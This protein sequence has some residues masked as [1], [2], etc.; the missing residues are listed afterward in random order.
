MKERIKRFIDQQIKEFFIELCKQK[1]K[2]SFQEFQIEIEFGFEIK[3]PLKKLD[4][5]D[6]DI[7]LLLYKRC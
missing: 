3:D 7:E 1:K 5:K 6:K 2:K 4:L